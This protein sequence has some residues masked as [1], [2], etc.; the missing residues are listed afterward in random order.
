MKKHRLEDRLFLIS[1]VKNGIGRFI[2]YCNYERHFG[3]IKPSSYQRCER[4]NCSHYLRLYISYKPLK[5]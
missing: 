3:V 5:T 4:R 1:P 2:P